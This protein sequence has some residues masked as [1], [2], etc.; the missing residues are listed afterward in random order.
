MFIQMYPEQHISLISRSP[1]LSPHPMLILMQ[2]CFPRLRLS[3]LLILLCH[4]TFLFESH[5][6]WNGNIWSKTLTVRNLHTAGNNRQIHYNCKLMQMKLP[7]SHKY[8]WLTSMRLNSA[9]PSLPNSLKCGLTVKRNLKAAK[10][11][12][13]AC[14]SGTTLMKRLQI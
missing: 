12:K 4:M 13:H 6:W 1:R 10:C 2:L 14:M 9:R 5:G 7:V 11:I 3:L 8:I